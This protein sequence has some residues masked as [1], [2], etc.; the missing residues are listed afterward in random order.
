[1]AIGREK[2]A[3]PEDVL[4]GIRVLVEIVKASG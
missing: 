2:V 3:R 1:M 4:P